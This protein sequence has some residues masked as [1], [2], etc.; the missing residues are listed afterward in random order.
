MSAHYCP[1]ARYPTDSFKRQ[2]NDGSNGTATH[3]VTKIQYGADATFNF[4]KKLEETISL[5]IC[6]ENLLKI[7]Y[8]SADA[9]GSIA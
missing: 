7:L 8:G 1:S 9:D 5:N 6:G 4:T 3:I 2:E